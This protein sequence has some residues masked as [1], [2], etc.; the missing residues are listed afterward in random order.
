MQTRADDSFA[1]SLWHADPIVYTPYN[2]TDSAR[3]EAG[4]NAMVNGCKKKSNMLIPLTQATFIAGLFGGGVH[5]PDQN[6]A[7]LIRM[8]RRMNVIQFQIDIINKIARVHTLPIAVPARVRAMHSH[9]EFISTEL[10]DNTYVG[11]LFWDVLQKSWLRVCDTI[12]LNNPG[13]PS[14][15]ATVIGYNNRLEGAWRIPIAWQ[16]NTAHLSRYSALTCQLIRTTLE[17]IRLS[18]RAMAVMVP[19][20]KS[21]GE[22]LALIRADA[23]VKALKV[24]HVDIATTFVTYIAD[25]VPFF[26]RGL[27]QALP[28]W[29]FNKDRL[30]Y[31]EMI[32]LIQ[33]P[34]RDHHRKKL[35][36]IMLEHYLEPRLHVLRLGFHRRYKDVPGLRCIGY[37]CMLLVVRNLKEW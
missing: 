6:Y 3:I 16:G 13:Y 12:S 4:I 19:V 33:V 15:G 31:T 24:V 14:D 28:G 27:E 5:P 11:R 8:G 17:E 7:A 30:M 37:E 34:V 18:E 22:Y 9:V 32:A 35:D 2:L 26:D 29:E 21:K 25:G 20:Y 23:S 36:A 10:R 1:H